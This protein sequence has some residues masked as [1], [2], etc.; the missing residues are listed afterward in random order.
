MSSE[1]IGVGAAPNTVVEVGRTV[2]RE[3]PPYCGFL[4]NKFML[5][6][7]YNSLRWVL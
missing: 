3:T 7:G 6:D 1:T 2:H 4:L 5:R